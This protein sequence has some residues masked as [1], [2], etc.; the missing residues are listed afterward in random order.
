MQHIQR[1][2]IRAQFA[3]RNLL[4]DAVTRRE[5]GDVP[6][7]VLI[8]LMTAGLV[9]AIWVVAE[10]QLQRMFERAMNSVTGG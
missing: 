2:L 6:G 3:A 5:R 1:S 4:D 8:T 7:W 10:D 9:A